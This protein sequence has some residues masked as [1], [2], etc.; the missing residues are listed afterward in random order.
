QAIAQIFESPENLAQLKSIKR[1]SLSYAPGNRTTAALVV[2][3]MINQLHWKF[4]DICKGAISPGCLGLELKEAEGA[5]IGEC[6]LASENASF[7]IKRESDSAFF[8]ADI[9]LPDGCEY[10]H[11]FP[12]GNADSLSL[13]DDELMLGG[14]HLV[15]LK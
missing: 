5:P 11:L 9:R 10:H 12:A 13:L 1:V 14:K 8:H 6:T 7:S 2:G 3:W 4:E 15:Y